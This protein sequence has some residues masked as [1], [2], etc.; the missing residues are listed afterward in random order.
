MSVNVKCFPEPDAL[1]PCEDV[2][3]NAIL[4]FSVWIVVVMAVVG[5]L[6]VLIVLMS[7]RFTM[8]VSKFLMCN[9]AFADLMM[10]IYLLLIAAIDMHTIGVYF[11]HALEWQ[12]GK[13]CLSLDN[14]GSD[15]IYFLSRIG[16]SSSG[17]YYRICKR[18]VHL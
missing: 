14:Y 16:L 7:S 10:G 8:T 5:N 18:V 3:G 6:A 17:I 4:R 1:N 12:E 11:N 15:P 9:L 2:M 13:I